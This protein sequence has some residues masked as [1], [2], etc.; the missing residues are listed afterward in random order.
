MSEIKT[1]LMLCQ[2][3]FNFQFN[4]HDIYNNLEIKTPIKNIFIFNGRN[5]I[6]KYCLSF[7]IEINGR[8]VK[9]KLF[10]TGKMS[11]PGLKSLEEHQ[12]INNIIIDLLK[13][14]IPNIQINHSRIISGRF[15]YNCNF[16]VDLNKLDREFKDYPKKY[17]S[18][19]FSGL[20]INFPKTTAYI[21]NSGKINIATNQIHELQNIKDIID[22]IVL[23]YK[24]I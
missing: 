13:D 8:I 24:K 23:T 1:A 10:R 7:E 11:I 9:P 17:N 3:I 16:K 18:E 14:I 4:E 22:S 5:K 19:R 12:T 21:F 20:I 2:T 15:F 6:F